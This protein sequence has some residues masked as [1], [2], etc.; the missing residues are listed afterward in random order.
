M[1]FYLSLFFL[2]RICKRVSQT[3][4]NK[5]IILFRKNKCWFVQGIVQKVKIA[6][7]QP[8]KD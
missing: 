8:G 3:N 4:V 2:L 5:I 6:T 1:L 7:L